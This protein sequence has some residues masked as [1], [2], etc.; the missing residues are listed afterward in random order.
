MTAVGYQD[1]WTEFCLIGITLR[2]DTEQ[3]WSG[4]TEKIEF[5]WGDKDIEGIP[6]VNGGRV[7]KRIPMTDES[8]TL[9]MYPVSADYDGAATS[10]TGAAQWFH[11]LIPYGASTGESTTEPN[12]AVNTNI[13]QQFQLVFVWASTLP[14]TASGATA[15]NASAYRITIKNAYMTKYKLKFDDYIMSAECTFKWAPFTKAAV[16]NKTEE[17]TTGGTVLGAVTAF[18]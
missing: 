7:V 18:T 5:D 4:M 11:T 15:A 1:A 2:G 8:V 16:S 3:L 6:L 13:R 14:T 10:A 12:T 9:T 17:D